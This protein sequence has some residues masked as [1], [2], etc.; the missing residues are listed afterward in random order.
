MKI[1]IGLLFLLVFLS[2]YG[3]KRLS[4]KT[5]G[6]RFASEAL[7]LAP[8]TSSTLIS[9]MRF[10][11]HLKL[12]QPEGPR[13]PASRSSEIN[14]WSIQKHWKQKLAERKNKL[15]DAEF[16][17][18][19]ID[20]PELWAPGVKDDQQLSKAWRDLKS[21][22]AKKFFRSGRCFES[23]ANIPAG[24]GLSFK[25]ELAFRFDDHDGESL[26]KPTDV[27]ISVIF[28]ERTLQSM[29]SEAKPLRRSGQEFLV[30]DLTSENSKISNLI[31]FLAVQA[32]TEDLSPV[33]ILYARSDSIEWQTVHSEAWVH[34]P[35]YSEAHPEEIEGHHSIN[36]PCAG[37]KL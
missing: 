37:A 27:D 19:K 25:L 12:N 10:A 14:F 35:S 33:Q 4:R 34:A 36:D 8:S 18:S 15:V 6:L 3:L 29:I 11:S 5:A 31:S 16:G 17:E 21:E 26:L 32:P 7:T 20:Q 24:D 1:R 9:K 23:S 2:V 30:F 28:D 13:K 22:I